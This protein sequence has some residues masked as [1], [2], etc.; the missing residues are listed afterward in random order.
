LGDNKK[1]M[2]KQKIDKDQTHNQYAVQSPRIKEAQIDLVTVA[3]TRPEIIKL[4]QLIP[5]LNKKYNH[6]LLYTGQH[7]S[8]NMKD[9]FFDELDI[10]PDYDLKSNTSD[11]AILRDNILRALKNIKPPYV[12]V[13][14]DT[15]SSM[16]A[17]L[18]AEQMG[19]K[20]IHIEA[21][22]RDFD[23]AVPEESIR[24]YID[25]KSA[26]MFAPSDF[27]HT[28][29]TYEKTTGQ[30]FTSGNLI[31]DVCKNLSDIARKRYSTTA[32]SEGNDNDNDNCGVN[33][34]NNNYNNNAEDCSSDISNNNSNNNRN[35]KYQNSDINKKNGRYQDIDL[36]KDD[37][38][39]LTV[40]R[41]ENSDDPSKLQMLRKHLAELKCNVIFP[42]HPRTLQNLARFG[43]RL[44]PNVKTIDAVG[45]LEFL[46]LL[47]NCK[48]V[49]TDSGGLQEES[50]VLKKPCITLRHTSARWETILLNA[51]VLFPLD[52]KDSLHTIVEKMA[53]AKIDRNPYGENVAKKVVDIMEQTI[54]L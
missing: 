30:I 44:P 53:G 18:A 27:C 9:I 43:I 6:A 2:S 5:L 32:I 13:Y 46:H 21:G 12:I 23:L 20:L 49:I 1:Y 42:V 11:I 37:F 25:S 16:A 3:G 31:V 14:G 22:V 10:R 40:H 48:L 47:N 17:T 8:E 34:N 35:E 29:L 52:R 33:G 15:N 36:E 28:V 50:V 51:N 4:A 24:I 38:L 26:Y 19:S 54:T 45:Y 7:F 39:L 41:P